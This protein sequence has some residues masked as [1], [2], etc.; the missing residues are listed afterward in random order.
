MGLDGFSNSDIAEKLEITLSSVKVLKAR[1]K[2]CFVSE[3]KKLTK[4]IER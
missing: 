4:S 2:S 3:M 1:V